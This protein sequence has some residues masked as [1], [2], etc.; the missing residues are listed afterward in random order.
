[1]SARSACTAFKFSCLRCSTENEK[2]AN[3]VSDLGTCTAGLTSC[4]RVS[5]AA[6][7]HTPQ[8][9]ITTPAGW[10]WV[11]TALCSAAAAGLLHILASSRDRLVNCV[12]RNTATVVTA[13]ERTLPAVT[14]SLEEP[15]LAAVDHLAAPLEAVADHVGDQV[16]QELIRWVG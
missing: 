1:V 15:L 7:P 4:S 10:R 9:S 8:R 2:K 16:D 11:V 6:H 12:D 13:L 14:H 5:S 3:G